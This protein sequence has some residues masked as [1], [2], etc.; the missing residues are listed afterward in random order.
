MDALYR[1]YRREKLMPVQL[2]PIMFP[3]APGPFVSDPC[4]P[5]LK[6]SILRANLNCISDK[7]MTES[8]DGVDQFSLR[9]PFRLGAILTPSACSSATF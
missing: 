9:V 1:R 5:S 8:D 3:R 2:I 6:Q 7:L 4:T